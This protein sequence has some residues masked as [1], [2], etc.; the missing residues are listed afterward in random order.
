MLTITLVFWENVIVMGEGKA[1][2]CDFGLSCILGDDST[3]L[4]GSSLTLE[5]CHA[6]PEL[7]RGGSPDLRSDIWAFGC[8]SMGV[9]QISTGKQE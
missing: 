2:L 7:I 4:T 8:T 6:S 3:S 5:P 1:Q 9:S